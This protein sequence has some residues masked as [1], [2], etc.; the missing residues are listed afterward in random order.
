MLEF[1]TAGKWVLWT[2][3]HLA[4]VLAMDLAREKE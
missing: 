1:V 3:L 4:M 2:E